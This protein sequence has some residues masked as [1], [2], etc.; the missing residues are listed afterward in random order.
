MAGDLGIDGKLRVD[1]DPM[2]L[3]TAGNLTTHG[4]ADVFTPRGDSLGRV[5]NIVG[6]LE[7]PIAI[8]KLDHEVK[9]GA[10]QLKGREVF[11]G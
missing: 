10:D 3:E 7:R 6:T 9:T 8:V 4:G 1:L 5:V 11:L 2:N